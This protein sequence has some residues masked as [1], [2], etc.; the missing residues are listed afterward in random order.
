M[1]VGSGTIDKVDALEAVLRRTAKLAK[2]RAFADKDEQLLNS[3]EF[4]ECGQLGLESDG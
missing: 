1:K 3:D 2:L 4:V